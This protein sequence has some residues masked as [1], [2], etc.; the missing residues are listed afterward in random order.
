M[1]TAEGRISGDNKNFLGQWEVNGFNV[2]LNGNFRQSVEKWSAS[3]ATLQY[4]DFND[5]IGT[6]MIDTEFEPYIGSSDLFL[7]FKSQSGRHIRVVSSLQYHLSQ[8]TDVT[9][10][11]VWQYSKSESD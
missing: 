6:Y 4:E 11:G 10:L 7:P 2:L 8:R 1:P 5:L 9:G 3:P